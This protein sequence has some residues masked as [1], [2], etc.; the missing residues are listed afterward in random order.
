MGGLSPGEGFFEVKT[1]IAEG[2]M[3]EPGSRTFQK[4][5]LDILW[6]D[7]FWRSF[8]KFLVH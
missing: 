2:G 3:F 6:V 4:C 5:D 1:L 7:Y 8:V